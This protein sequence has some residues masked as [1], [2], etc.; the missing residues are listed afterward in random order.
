MVIEEC[1][2]IND[3]T[4]DIKKLITYWREESDLSR[5][6]TLSLF[7]KKKYPEA[8]FFGHLTLEKMLKAILVA[9]TNKHA[10][11]IHNLLRLAELAELAMTSEQIS[12]LQQCTV[13]YLAGR[14]DEEKMSFRKKCT[15][16]FT[17]KY[18]SVITDLY[19]WLKREFQKTISRSV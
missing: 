9:K 8:L 3:M 10:P 13:F 1:Y 17:K 16:L 18:I 15:P 4:T 12:G 11:P 6:V 7:K 5:E 2:H 14:Y 19:I